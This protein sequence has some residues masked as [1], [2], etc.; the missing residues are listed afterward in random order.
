MDTDEKEYN[1]SYTNK[2]TN[3]FDWLEVGLSLCDRLNWQKTQ[4]C[5]ILVSIKENCR[6]I[7]RLQ[8]VLREC[9]FIFIN[10]GTK[11]FAFTITKNV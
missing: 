9:T 1:T 6:L 11:Q 7:P 8:S 4:A 2:K 10:Q 3:L 5:L